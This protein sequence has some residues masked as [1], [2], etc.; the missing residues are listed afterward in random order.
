[1][2]QVNFEGQDITE[3]ISI[4]A[5]YHDMYAEK[6]SDTLSIRFNDTDNLWDKWQPKVGDEITV[7][8][9]SIGTGKMYVYDAL[10]TNGLYELR[11]ASA[12]PSVREVKNK[13]W[14]QISLLKMGAEI[15]ENH[16]LSFISYGVED[17]LYP[18]ILQEN[19]TDFYFL[20]KRCELE[21]CAFLV[22]DNKLVLYSEPY[23]ENQEPI[24][25]L[26]IGLDDDYR[27]Q[28]D[29]ARLYGSCTI[30]R[31]SYQGSFDGEN[32]MARVYTPDEKIMVGSAA[33]AERFA[34]NLLR[35]KNKNAKSGYFL[36]RILPGYAAASVLK[37]QNERAPSWDGNIFLTHV[38][39]DYAKGR[40]KLFFR[41]PLEGY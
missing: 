15:A 40:A 27:Y 14:Q 31:G 5:C 16:G 35:S 13:A 17:Y 6:Q 39:N 21:G 2:I 37:L 18:Y 19:T 34:K 28:N 4:N 26:P 7:N 10:P 8:Y 1:M 33:E 23:M 29:T 11:A 9:G 3:N 22:Y 24:E 32:G 25:T 20:Q 38:R 36:G 30:E 12:P 41:K